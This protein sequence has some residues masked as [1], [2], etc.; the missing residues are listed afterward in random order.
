MVKFSPSYFIIGYLI[1]A[2]SIFGLVSS[3]T[4]APNW[5]KGSFLFMA[6]TDFA[7]LERSGRCYERLRPGNFKMTLPKERI[8]HERG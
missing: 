4:I 2:K 8:S 1:W 5:L 3:A 7:A 6:L